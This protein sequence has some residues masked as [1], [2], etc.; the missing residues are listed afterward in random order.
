M[1]LRCTRCGEINRLTT[2]EATE[3]QACK[4]CGEL[5]AVRGRAPSASLARERLLGESPLSK[6]PLRKAGM[7]WPPEQTGCDLPAARP[8]RKLPTPAPTVRSVAAPTAVETLTAPPP[9]RRR[10]RGSFLGGLPWLVGALGLA[11]L[12]AAQVVWQRPQLLDLH[13]ALRPL[14]E[15]GCAKVGCTVPV[16]HA[17][18]LLAIVSSRLDP[19][20]GVPGVSELHA[21]L[22]NG[23]D[24]AQP[25][26]DLRLT[27]LDE[28]QRALARRTLSPAEYLP[29]APPR[30]PAGASA[31]ARVLVEASPA[32]VWGFTVALVP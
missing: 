25:L 27:F 23:A 14:A 3:P 1:E 29:A 24:F 19:V 12:A 32:E 9:R 21:L 7:P 16:A 26:P 6:L 5:L 22:R 31:E 28:A 17:P 8:P 10:R 11:G 13:P 4:R 15:R 20:D 2:V 30:L 18:Q